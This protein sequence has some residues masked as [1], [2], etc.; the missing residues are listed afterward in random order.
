MRHFISKVYN[1]V[2][3]TRRSLIRLLSSSRTDRCLLSVAKRC[4]F[5]AV[6]LVYTVV[7]SSRSSR[8]TLSEP[9]AVA[10]QGCSD[11][12]A[13]SRCPSH[14]RSWQHR[15]A[16][17]TSNQPVPELTATGHPRADWPFVSSRALDF[18]LVNAAGC[19]WSLTWLTCVRP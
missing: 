17:R 13:R 12:L 2:R 15:G 10:L 5:V 3:S 6:H 8:L 4:G 1:R 19:S 9:S 7:K 18:G 14:E 11:C 16:A